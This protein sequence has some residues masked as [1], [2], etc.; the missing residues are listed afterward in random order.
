MDT[1]S[2]DVNSDYAFAECDTPSWNLI[3]R[4]RMWRQDAIIQHLY[5]TAVF[6]GDKILAWTSELRLL[7]LAS[8]IA[9]DDTEIIGEP[10]DA[11][12]LAQ[13]YFLMAEYH[14]A[15]TILTSNLPSPKLPRSYASYD[16]DLAEGHN[17]A[18]LM[19]S[20]EREEAHLT[21][22]R[23]RHSRNRSPT[24]S[25]HSRDASQR[26]WQCEDDTASFTG[27]LWGALERPSDSYVGKLD[28][29][30]DNRIEV[31]SVRGAMIDWSM[32]CRYLATLCLVRIFLE[33]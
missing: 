29:A 14:R 9:I 25:G 22:T 23:P 21:S 10:N 13:A 33:N 8:T 19:A 18:G 15:E 11:F 2:S 12:W 32:A 6:W 1:Q 7:S 31:E 3:R 4:M 16:N 30:A 28:T 27:G 26:Q 24:L 17:E 5:Q 20:S